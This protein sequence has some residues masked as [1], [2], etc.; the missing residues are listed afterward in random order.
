MKEDTRVEGPWEWGDF[1]AGG[2]GARNDLKKFKTAIQSG[3]RKAALIEE[4]TVMMARYPRFYNLVKSVSRPKRTNEILVRLNFG[5]TGTGKTRYAFETYPNIFEIPI[6]NGTLW[7][8][9]YD[10]HPEVLFDDFCGAASKVA[11]DNI[12]KLLDRYP[13]QV[14]VKGEYVWYMPDVIIV[15]SNIHPRDW[16]DYSDRREQYQALA[17]RFTEIWEYGVDDGAILINKDNFF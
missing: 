8:D 4:H 5:A 17:R 3:K 2:Q 7:F 12:L 14:P 1:T 11:L 13:R 15:T 6:S 9:G 16:Y 10:M